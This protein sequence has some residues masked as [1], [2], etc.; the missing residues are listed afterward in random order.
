M[1]ERQT[2]HPAPTECGA[3]PKPVPFPTTIIGNQQAPVKL[4]DEAVAAG[5]LSYIDTPRLSRASVLIYPPDRMRLLPRLLNQCRQDR[6][7]RG[8]AAV[9][10]QGGETGHDLD[11][12]LAE[13]YRVSLGDYPAESERIE[14][15]RDYTAAAQRSRVLSELRDSEWDY[16]GPILE[17][18]KFPETPKA[19]MKSHLSPINYGCRPCPLFRKCDF[20]QAV[21][22]AQ[23]Y[24]VYHRDHLYNTMMDRQGGLIVL[25]A[26][27]TDPR[28]Q[29]TYP[30]R[31]I[32]ESLRAKRPDGRPWF[33]SFGTVGLHLLHVLAESGTSGPISGDDLFRHL[34]LVVGEKKVAGLLGKW[35]ETFGGVLSAEALTDGKQD[36]L[37]LDEFGPPKMLE[38]G[39]LGHGYDTTIG[40]PEMSRILEALGRDYHWYKK[41]GDRHPRISVNRQA[42]VLE[43]TPWFLEGD[44]LMIVGDEAEVRKNWA[45]L[46]REFV[47]LADV[48]PEPAGKVVRI[49]DLLRL[50]QAVKRAR[51]EGV[52]ELTATQLAER[53]DVQLPAVSKHRLKLEEL[54]GCWSDEAMRPQTTGPKAGKG[55]SRVR[56]FH[57]AEA[58]ELAV[59]A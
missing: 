21:Q 48:Q 15:E 44:L 35:G 6:V 2:P 37:A 14:L 30:T 56:V 18:C 36:G 51:C 1:R 40:G 34:E 50:V 46:G 3:D 9:W 57:L 59:V 32:H 7:P 45:W 52:T 39:D 31:D 22:G 41:G 24:R 4:N 49:T 28:S 16:A 33:S 23:R 10:S 42:V 20:W 26:D 25:L 58:K 12:N 29:F 5:F 43:Y 13:L 53:A 17:L 19:L 27:G 54:T 11:Y 8:G 55:T 38:P 47:T